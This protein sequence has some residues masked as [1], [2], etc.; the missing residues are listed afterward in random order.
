MFL[1]STSKFEWDADA[2]LV[3]ATTPSRR[4]INDFKNFHGHSFLGCA[5]AVEKI[6]ISLEAV[7]VSGSSAI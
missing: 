4:N 3:L 2:A 6:T 7:A 1:I 5:L